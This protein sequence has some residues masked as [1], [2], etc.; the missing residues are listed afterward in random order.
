M[1]KG[2]IILRSIDATCLALATITHGF[3]NNAVARSSNNSLSGCQIAAGRQRQDRG[4]D[5]DLRGRQ[6][7][8]NEIA[9]PS[10]YPLL[11]S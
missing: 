10:H 9:E 3:L 4:P 5:P 7:P 1:S 8:R 6:L 2:S 11:L